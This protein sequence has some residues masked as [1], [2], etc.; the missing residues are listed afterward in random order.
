MDFV[1]PRSNVACV[2]QC[3][4]LW[5]GGKGWGVTWKLNQC[6][7]KP[8]VQETVYGKCHITL[9]DND[10]QTIEQSAHVN[11][12]D[13]IGQD[14]VK[15]TATTTMVEDSDN[16]E[17]DGSETEHIEDVEPV[18]VAEPVT[19]VKKKVVKKVVSTPVKEDTVEDQ[20]P[21]APKKKVVRKKVSA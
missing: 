2:L 3:G 20:P 11:D 8:F 4:G 21:A 14:T 16:D 9:S 6:V 19:P 10:I 12:E 1:P 15:E 7:V 18:I 17:D 5:F 13:D